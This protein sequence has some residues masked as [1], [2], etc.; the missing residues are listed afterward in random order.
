MRK[1]WLQ[2]TPIALFIALFV[3]T[4]VILT[5]RGEPQAFYKLS[6]LTAIIP[7]LVLGWL[8]FKGSMA[9]RMTAFLD[10]ARH[11][12]IITMCFIFLLAGAFSEITKAIGSVDATVGCALS[13][14]PEKFLLIGIF[15]TAAFISTAIG[16]SMGTIATLAPLA[17][18]LCQQGGLSG[19]LTAATVVGGAMFG[20]NLSLISDTTLAAVMSQEAD[21]RAKLRLNASVA[22][23]AGLCTLLLLGWLSMEM[24]GG[25]SASG[26]T[27]AIG[28]T[29]GWGE[30]SF[31]VV[32]MSPY[33]LLVALALSGVN[34]F[35]TLLV[36]I[37]YASG[38]GIFYGG[39]SFFAMNATLIKGFMSMYEIMLL[40]LLVGGLSGLSGQGAHDLAAR[41]SHWVAQRTEKNSGKGGQGKRLTQAVIAGMVSLF[42]LLLANNTIAIIV[43]GGIA[44]QL[45]QK[46]KI[47]AHYSAAWLDIFSCVFQGIIP[48]GAQILLA[49]T[50]IGVSPLSVVPHVYYCF[51]LGITAIAVIISVTPSNRQASS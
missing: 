9:D 29:G 17:A 13:F 25:S 42:D 21:M 46:H 36:S 11:R 43:S 35:V 1:V 38:L 30:G 8:L 49:S 39:Q 18:G 20:D 15:L 16:T 19:A 14:I 28:A 7:S 6:P 4:G 24:D 47:P 12:D 2:F 45:A 44:R 10:G 27:G 50:V 32:L 3:G 31:S 41:M 22:G 34:V 48:Y 51:F 40:S 33:V 23:I 26:T 37:F 5:L